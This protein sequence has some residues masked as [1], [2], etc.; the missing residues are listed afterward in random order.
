MHP[1]NLRG[2]QAFA[3]ENTTTGGNEKMRIEKNKERDGENK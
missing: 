1:A 3:E 2:R